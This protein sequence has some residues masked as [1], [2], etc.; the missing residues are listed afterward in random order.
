MLVY[1]CMYMYA[2]ICVHVYVCMYVCM[3][4]CVYVCV[5]MYMCMCVYACMYMYVCII[6]WGN[7]PG[8]KCPGGIVLHSVRPRF[9]LGLEDVLLSGGPT[10]RRC[11]V[12]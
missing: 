5:Y 1:V 3:Y 9:A 2:C 4:V 8:G 10:S 11:C 7:C 6:Y 12:S